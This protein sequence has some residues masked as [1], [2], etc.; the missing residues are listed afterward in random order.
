MDDGATSHA[1]LPRALGM[2]QRSA[3][4]RVDLICFLYQ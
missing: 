1:H 4:N 2:M 3:S